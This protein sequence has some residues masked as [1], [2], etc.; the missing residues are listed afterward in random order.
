M[1][2]G[3]VIRDAVIHHP[4]IRMAGHTHSNVCGTLIHHAQPVTLLKSINGARHFLIV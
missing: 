3:R 4:A 1:P 2:T